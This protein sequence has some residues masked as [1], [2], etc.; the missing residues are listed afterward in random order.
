MAN[1]YVKRCSRSL[2]FRETQIKTTVRK[3]LAPTRVATVKK[4]QKI[5]V[6]K[7]VEKLE[8]LALWVG[9]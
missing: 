4:A 6:G 5:N 1:S 8:P 9:M 3:H 2:I 7:D